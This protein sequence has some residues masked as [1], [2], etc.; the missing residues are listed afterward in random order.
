MAYFFFIQCRLHVQTIRSM[1][2]MCQPE[3]LPYHQKAALELTTQKDNQRLIRG[4]YFGLF[5][6]LI[7]DLRFQRNSG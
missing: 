2:I 7:V 4:E 3:F 1:K 5:S 6:F